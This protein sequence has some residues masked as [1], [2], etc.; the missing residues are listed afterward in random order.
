MRVNSKFKIILTIIISILTLLILHKPIDTFATE[1][2]IEEDIVENGDYTLPEIYNI[3]WKSLT[4]KELNTYL[5]CMT[6]EELTE[7]LFSLE[8]D[9]IYDIIERNTLLR[10]PVY[11]ATLDE[12]T[13]ESNLVIKYDHFYEKLFS[14]AFSLYDWDNDTHGYS[15]TASGKCYVR[16]EDYSGNLLAR[17]RVKVSNITSGE[18][19]LSGDQVEISERTAGCGMKITKVKT[20]KKT[21]TWAGL[22]LIGYYTLPA[23]TRTL[24][25][26]DNLGWQGRFDPWN[27]DYNKYSLDTSHHTGPVTDDFDIQVNG[28]HAGLT[29]G[30]V[31]GDEGTIILVKLKNKLTIKPNGGTY[32]GST[33]D[34]TSTKE[35]GE[36]TS[37]SIPTREGYRFNGWTLSNGSGA[38]GSIA[39][40][41]AVATTFTHC[42][43]G[44]TLDFDAD[45]DTI[46]SYSPVTVNST[47]T[48]KWTA[49]NYNIAFNA[50][51]GSGTMANMSSVPYD[52]TVTL[53]A[54]A[55]TRTGYSFKGWATSASGSKVYNDKASV[56][57]LT[58]TNGG[59]VTLYA[60]WEINSYT[61]TVKPNGGT[62]NS[63]TTDSTITQNYQTSYTVADATRTGYRFNDWTKSGTGTFDTDTNKWT[64]GAGNGTLTAK[65]LANEYKVVY[66]ANKPSNA[67][68]NVTGSTAT[69]DHV[70]DV[71]KNLTAN[72]FSLVGHSFNGWNTKTDGSGTSY[73]N[74]QSVKNLTATHGG[75]VNLYVKWRAHTYSVVYNK[76]KP[77]TASSS[78]TGTMANSSYTY[79]VSSTLRTNTYKLT[80][81]IFQGWNTKADGSGTH[82]DDGATVKNWT[83]TDGGSITLY[84]QWI[85]ITYTLKYDS[86]SSY[87]TNA[88]ITG[89]GSST[90]L[91]Y[92]VDYTVE[93][94]TGDPNNFNCNT[95][96][97]IFTHWNT[98]YDNSGTSFKPGDNAVNLTTTNNGTVTLYAYYKVQYRVHHYL[99]DSDGTYPTIP[100]YTDID[101]NYV[102]TVVGQEKIKTLSGYQAPYANNTNTPTNGIPSK[103]ITVNVDY[104]KNEIHY[105]YPKTDF[106]VYVDPNSGTWRGST[107]VTTV[108]VN[109]GG[110]ETIELP[111]NPYSGT[112]RIYFDSSL[113]GADTLVGE[114]PV[115]KIF[116]GWTHT[117]GG[118]LV[119]NKVGNSTFTYKQNTTTLQAINS[120]DAYLTANYL[121]GYY[122]LKTSD[123]P[124]AREHYKFLGWNID[125][126]I[127]P[128]PEIY[129]GDDAIYDP[130]VDAQYQLGNQ[131]ADYV[132]GDKIYILEDPS[133]GKTYIYEDDVN[134]WIEANIYEVWRVDF[135]LDTIL[136][137]VLKPDNPND[138]GFRAGESGELDF[139]TIG[140]VDE[141]HIIFDDAIVDEDDSNPVIL[142]INPELESKL[143]Y[144]FNIALYAPSGAYDIE[145]IAYSKSY[146]DPLYSHHT[147]LV[148]GKNSF[149][150]TIVREM[151]TRIR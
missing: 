16:I 147:I 134:T 42:N 126:T 118:E 138:P 93:D 57:N 97:Y 25:T 9:D 64:Y 36:K 140:F 136:T 144:N 85:P 133:T 103:S 70:Y 76:N 29:E 34:T 38:S 49:C 87:F 108:N 128:N 102:G 150:D 14:E 124:A 45:G 65:W 94:Y 56:K 72:G 20:D 84:A 35:C 73:S 55:F 116:D 63:K 11:T 148:R 123:V 104:E 125:P 7:F 122:Q 151:K 53:T 46:D 4:D 40:T 28:F 135:E 81:W 69:S 47:V 83:T 105:F 89:G 82:Y 59:T 5:D 12:E 31:D 39:S 111:Q 91:T 143:R 68:N 2:I 32:N 114:R 146:R 24:W 66:N 8:D 61:L 145:I 17:W 129:D 1:L 60:V 6:D 19:T 100:D 101:F 58:T 115:N 54:N 21:H 120:G 119:N 149:I 37:L 18:Y 30:G 74:Q 110:T 13:D 86:N 96:N 26:S 137:R 132:V 95:D 92:D 127:Y 22:R 117:G 130:T 33:S 62:W 75:T 98:K 52:K 141:I 44:A 78:V 90:T 27:E 15:G 107:N 48:A 43:S 99:Q 106:N 80:G 113:D 112:L 3:D 79:D 77:S 71:A 88:E 50:N 23:H 121:I 67:T 142:N 51:G 131:V 109:V 10:N 139:E 41:A